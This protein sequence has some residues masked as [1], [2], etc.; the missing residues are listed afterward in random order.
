MVAENLPPWARMALGYD[1]DDKVAALARFG[2]DAGLCRDLHLAMIRYSRRN[3]TDGDVPATEPARLAFPLPPDDTAR[4]VEHLAE[5]ELILPIAGAMAP[6]MAPA[7]TPVMAPATPSM[8][9]GW[10]VVNYSKWNE[11]AAEIEKYTADQRER[12]RRGAE[13]RWG[14]AKGRGS[15]QEVLAGAKAGAMAGAM[16]GPMRFDGD[17]MA[18]VEVEVDDPRAEVGDRGSPARAREA[19]P[20]DDQDDEE[21]SQVQALMAAAGRP[22]GR[23]DASKILAAVLAKA[24]ARVRNRRAFIGRVLGDQKQARAYAPGAVHHAPSAAEIIAA[25]RHPGGPS[26]DVGDRAAEARKALANRER[27]A[28]RPEDDGD[29]DPMRGLWGEELARAQLAEARAA[30]GVIDPEP[31]A[32]PEAPGEPGGEP[33]AEDAQESAADDEEF[34]PPF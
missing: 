12:G 30:R 33:E 25:S 19:S 24:G 29:R 27:P 14:R 32:D 5:V 28:A 26:K 8:A 10:H 15:D 1:E 21:L 4:L 9:G 17:P 22:V 23:E 13:A 7:M 11:T 2:A 31:A 34:V 20:D 6:A 3:G 16:A 18:E